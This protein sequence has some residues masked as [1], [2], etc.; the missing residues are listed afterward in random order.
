MTKLKHCNQLK[1]FS[2][3]GLQL[4][5]IHLPGINPHK[6]NLLL[7]CLVTKKAKQNSSHCDFK[8]FNNPIQIIQNSIEQLTKHIELLKINLKINRN[9]RLKL[10]T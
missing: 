10:H 3:K 6:K 5:G 7:P 9:T 1:H 2:P 4:A 8:I